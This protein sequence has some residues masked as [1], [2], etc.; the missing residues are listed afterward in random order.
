LIPIIAIMVHFA[1]RS[2]A[3]EAY[4]RARQAYLD[5][6]EKLKRD[7]RSPDLRDRTLALGREYAAKATLCLQNAISGAANFDEVALMNDINAA[8]ARADVK[9]GADDG[10]AKLPVEERLAKLQELRAKQ[11]ITE[12]EYQSRRAQ[13]LQEV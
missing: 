8:C 5:S 10:K 1:K 12:Q 2:E 11:L 4:Q 9:A 6:L 7:P 3:K 13:I